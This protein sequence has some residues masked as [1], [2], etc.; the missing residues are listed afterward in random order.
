[1]AG[2]IWPRSK[3]WEA[4]LLRT[5]L[6]D[7]TQIDFT[8]LPDDISPLVESLDGVSLA[9]NNFFDLGIDVFGLV[10]DIETVAYL[11][12]ANFEIS[13]DVLVM[14]DYLQQYDQSYFSSY[15]N[16][17][18]SLQSRIDSI[19]DNAGEGFFSSFT[20]M[21]FAMFWE[22]VSTI[23]TAAYTIAIESA[24]GFGGIFETANSTFESVAQND[25]IELVQGFGLS[26]LSTVRMIEMADLFKELLLIGGRMVGGLHGLFR[27]A[28]LSTP[29]LT[30]S[31][32]ANVLTDID[33]RLQLWGVDAVPAPL[34][35]LL[36]LGTTIDEGVRVNGENAAIMAVM[37][38]PA[39][40][41]LSRDFLEDALFV[42]RLEYV[43]VVGRLLDT[44]SAAIR[45][46][47]P[48][49][50]TLLNGMT[51]I[52]QAVLA[53]GDLTSIAA[54]SDWVQEMRRYGDLVTLT[55]PM[56]DYQNLVE[57]ALNHI[58]QQIVGYTWGTD[59]PSVI[60]E[61]VPGIELMLSARYDLDDEPAM[62]RG[63]TLAIGSTYHGVFSHYSGDTDWFKVTLVEGEDYRI[64]FDTVN[65][66]WP[67]LRLLNETGRV[68]GQQNDTLSNTGVAVMQ[69]TALASATYYLVLDAHT[70]PD[71]YNITIESVTLPD[72][73]TELFEMSDS[74]DTDH[75]L[76]VGQTLAGRL[77]GLGDYHARADWVRIELEEGLDYRILLSGNINNLDLA[78][79]DS[80]GIVV[81]HEL[82][83]EGRYL[84]GT[85]VKGGSYFVGISS[86]GTGTYTLSFEEVALPNDLTELVDAK[87]SVETLYGLAAGENFFGTINPEDGDQ[88]AEGL[89]GDWVRVSMIAGQDYRITVTE[90]SQ[91]SSA[92]T[93]MNS[94]GEQV[95]TRN[96]ALS[97]SDVSMIQGTALTTGTYYVSTAGASWGTYSINFEEV[98]LAADLSEMRDALGGI[99]TRYQIEA[100]QRFWGTLNDRDGDTSNQSDPGGDWVQV[101]MVAGQDY[102]ITLTEDTLNN[103]E[104]ALYDASGALV[105]TENQSLS[106]TETSIM[107]GTALSGGTFY[108]ASLAAGS[109]G[110]Y[111]IDFEE[112]TPAEDLVELADAR[113]GSETLYG[114]DVGDRF[115]GTLSDRDGDTSNQ[116]DPGGDWVAVTLRAGEF[117]RFTLTELSLSNGELALYD[118]AGRLVQAEDAGLS[119]SGTSVVQGTAQATGTFYI[120]SL[121]TGNLGS[122]TIDFAINEQPVSTL[123][124]RYQVDEG[125]FS[126]D[127]NSYF[128]D[129]N[130]DAISYSI[131]GLPVTLTQQG[132]VISGTLEARPEPLILSVEASDGISPVTVQFD[133]DVRNINDAPTGSLQV[134]GFPVEGNT[135]SVSPAIQDKDGLGE[136]SFQWLRGD[137]DMV[138]ATEDSYL[139]SQGDVGAEI[140]VRVSYVDG[141]GTSESIESLASSPVSNVNDPVQGTPTVT[142]TPTQGETLVADAT[143]LSDADGMGTVSFQWTRGGVD[144]AGATGT[145]YQ[146][147]QE[148]VGSGYAVRASYVDG[149]GTSES[150]TSSSTSPVQSSNLHLT[151]TL[152]TDTLDGAE[153]DDTLEG[154]DG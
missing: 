37:D 61:A 131:S 94:D 2:L 34:E 62:E 97:N 95:A 114:I 86:V 51:L 80:L 77:G 23:S 123:P 64:T 144:I 85:A 104:V 38:N 45:A 3:Y 88:A 121:A 120:A 139:L 89:S 79:Y 115:R 10:Y 116:S 24:D 20:L 69:G 122:Y 48:Q 135:L 137:E 25:Y 151:G 127:L 108:I 125:A 105:A 83:S 16:S 63:G 19:I 136:F 128:S 68:I 42:N 130:G 9:K 7:F 126:L 118:S 132:G 74:P 67:D 146:L 49:S 41:Q 39:L 28:P 149:Y 54:K 12:N 106:S 1:M 66:R 44:V 55:N 148:D 110:S 111:T 109:L 152:G 93:L 8:E 81:G 101:S 53:A 103:G 142:G 98:E 50:Q 15:K 11:S 29:A 35:I 90:G 4:Q 70:D 91:S 40:T 5:H 119:T 87:G 150:A 6:E 32:F 140:S 143:G 134:F 112:F 92:V 113:G 59:L 141:F 46:A 78:L 72:D 33:D 107:E 154:L 18:A 138:G 102:R 100:G 73:V 21:N 26:T 124:A 47:Q 147:T 14:E 17:E 71:G 82:T 36:Q 30:L 133:L 43:D 22:S 99:E 56:H 13:V 27:D 145:S 58:D 52:K 117:Y 153:G 31:D 96:R 129:P 57:S 76:E 75:V 84:E 60:P 65:H